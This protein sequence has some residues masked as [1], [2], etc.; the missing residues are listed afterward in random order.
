MFAILAR[1]EVAQ[2]WTVEKQFNVKYCHKLKNRRILSKTVVLEQQGSICVVL[3][4]LKRIYRTIKI[5][6]GFLSTK[7][8]EINTHKPTETEKCNINTQ[9]D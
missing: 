2:S 6:Q 8:W 5:K 9:T 7:S 4:R 1:D 3:T